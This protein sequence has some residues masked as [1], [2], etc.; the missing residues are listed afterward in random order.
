MKNVE[1]SPL[2]KISLDDTD[3]NEHNR[4]PGINLS[5]VKHFSTNFCS[6]NT[7]LAGKNNPV[8]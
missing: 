2:S 1:V 4:Y 8:P 6:M 7:L 3:S 5:T